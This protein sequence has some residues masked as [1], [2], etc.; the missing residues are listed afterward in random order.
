MERGRKEVRK[1]ETDEA[2]KSAARKKEV[3][4]FLKRFYR[5]K[6]E[7][8]IL[9]RRLGEL[10]RATD[11]DE[12][13][14]EV[15]R[16]LQ[17]QDMELRQTQLEIIQILDRLPPG[18]TERVILGLRH[19]DCKSWAEIQRAVHYSRSQ[20]FEYYGRGIDT[21]A[22]DPGAMR[23]IRGARARAAVRARGEGGKQ[24]GRKD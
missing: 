12:T 3:R 24:E 13:T 2:R 8:M 7:G 17:R 19:I 23:I 6:Q 4:L 20:C 15:R 18:T 10:S 9:H 14:M 16:L 5:T 1:T 22:S 21:L 11:S